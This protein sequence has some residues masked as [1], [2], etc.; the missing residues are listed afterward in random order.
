VPVYVNTF[1]EE[2]VNQLFSLERGRAVRAEV[3]DVAGVDM[4]TQ[5]G[6]PSAPRAVRMVFTGEK[7]RKEYPEPI[8]DI[9][10]LRVIKGIRLV[11]LA[12][13]VRMKLTRFRAKDEAHINDLDEAGLI[14]PEIEARLSETLRR[15]L[16]QARARARN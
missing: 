5:A 14:T 13:L 11:P 9:G 1:F 10:P 7:V 12:D 6:E 3:R 8:P 2:R 16:V 15:R 4:L